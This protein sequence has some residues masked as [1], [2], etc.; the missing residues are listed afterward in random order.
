MDELDIPR[1]MLPKAMPSS[2]IFGETDPSIFGGPIKIAG[3]AGD[4]QCALFGQTC[5]DKG[6]VKNTY[7]TGCFMLMNTG[8]KPIFSKS[9][10]VTTIA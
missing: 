5:F 8:E 1:Q 7:G 9:N 10:L 3:A 2:G 6:D 4:Q